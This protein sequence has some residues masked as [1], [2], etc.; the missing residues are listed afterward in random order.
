MAIEDFSD[1]FMTCTFVAD[2]KIFINLFHNHSYTH[3]HFVWDLTN[4]EIWSPP[5]SLETENFF[6]HRV[7]GGI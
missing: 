5:G 6:K 4:R 7:E 1:P 2:D 3:Y